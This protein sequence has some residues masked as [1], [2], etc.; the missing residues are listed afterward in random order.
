MTHRIE[1]VVRRGM[2]IGCGA[3]SA[4]TGGAIPIKLGT[5]RLYQAD[6]RGFRR[7]TVAWVA[8]SVPS[9]TSLQTKMN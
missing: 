7:R 5:H 8:W 1:E 3:C 2:C 4:A 9:Q 6:L